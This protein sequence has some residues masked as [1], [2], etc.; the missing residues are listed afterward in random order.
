MPLN[1]AGNDGSNL[2]NIIMQMDFIVIRLSSQLSGRGNCG[3]VMKS[4]HKLS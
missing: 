1:A 2:N 4:Q 3:V